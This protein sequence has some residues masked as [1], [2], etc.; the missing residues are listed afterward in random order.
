M[1]KNK[2]KPMKKKNRT[3]GENTIHVLQ[4]QMWSVRNGEDMIVKK[5][6]KHVYRLFKII[7]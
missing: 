3:A 5:N 6:L 1:N 4:K 2:N 7:D